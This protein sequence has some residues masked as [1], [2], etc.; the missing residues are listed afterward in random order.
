MLLR[1]LSGFPNPNPPPDSRVVPNIPIPI[2]NRPMA[3][4]G[5]RLGLLSGIK[6]PIKYM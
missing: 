1:K 4:M 6:R 3:G 5:R 2:I